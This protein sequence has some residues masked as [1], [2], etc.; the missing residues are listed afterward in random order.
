MIYG[1]TPFYAEALVNTYSNIMNHETTLKFPDEP[2]LSSN[3]KDII[4]RLLS[5]ADIRLGRNGPNDLRSHPFFKNS[6][7]SFATLK[8]A[9]PPV[10]PELKG[11]DDTTNFDVSLP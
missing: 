5:R 7:W 10:V 6:E 2:T 8:C 11:D 4:K 9:S 3:G 1:D